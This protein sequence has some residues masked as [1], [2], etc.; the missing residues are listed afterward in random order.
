MREDKS[1]RPLREGEDA[2]KREKQDV[3]TSCETHVRFLA[4]NGNI[5]M[6]KCICTAQESR[7]QEAKRNDSPQE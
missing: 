1:R 6:A 2:A 7:E 3:T 5:L 4:C